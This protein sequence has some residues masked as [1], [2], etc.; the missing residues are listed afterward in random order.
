MFGPSPE[1]TGVPS[2]AEGKRRSEMV[3][4]FILMCCGSGVVRV[5]DC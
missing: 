1:A 3:E 5:E 2:M 4:S